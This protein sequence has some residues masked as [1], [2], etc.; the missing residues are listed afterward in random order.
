VSDF[1]PFLS[2]SHGLCYTFNGKMKNV[3]N[4]SVRYAHEYGGDG[5]LDLQ[6]YVHSD[7]YVPYFARGKNITH[8]ILLLLLSFRYWYNW[9]TT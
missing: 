5:I 1:V 2:A 4:D 9:F 3:S 8:N 7:Q 6:L